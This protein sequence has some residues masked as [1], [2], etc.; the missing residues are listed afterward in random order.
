MT[1]QAPHQAPLEITPESAQRLI[2]A[3][4]AAQTQAYAPYSRFHVG[5]ALLTASGEII[6][7]TNVENKS[8]GLT[9]CAERSAVVRAVVQGVRS[10]IAVAIV[11]DLATPT[12]PCGACREVLSEFAPPSTPVFLARSDNTYDTHTLGAL[13]PFAFQL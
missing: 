4:R 5:A 2:L 3:A 11:S 8:Y 6:T 1:N 12:P 10:F 7:G 13:L 9:I